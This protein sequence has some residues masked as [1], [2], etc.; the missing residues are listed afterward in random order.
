MSWGGGGVSGEEEGPL[1]DL[2][3]PSS[4][5]EV[6][7]RWGSGAC[8]ALMM[9]DALQLDVLTGPKALCH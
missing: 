4:G 2:W 8:T 6:S 9:T 1:P 5:G 7:A 3:L